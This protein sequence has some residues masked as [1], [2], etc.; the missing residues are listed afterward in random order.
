MLKKYN[1]EK[2]EDRFNILP[3]GEEVLFISNP[4]LGL[5]ANKGRFTK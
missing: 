2:L 4:A 3:D 5:C 1:P